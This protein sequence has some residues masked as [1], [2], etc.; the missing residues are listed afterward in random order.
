VPV[1]GGG[2]FR[3]NYNYR[4]LARHLPDLGEG[5]YRGQL[6]VLNSRLQEENKNVPVTLK[7]TAGPILTAP[8]SLLFRLGEGSATYSAG[9]SLGN[10]GAGTLAVSEVRVSTES[11]GEWLA[12]EI[13]DEGRGVQLKVQPAGLA[14]GIHNG[15]VELI[16]NAANSPHAVPVLFEVL[17]AGPPAADYATVTNLA[18]T[19]PDPVVSPGMLVK[20]RGTQITAMEETTAAEAPYPSTLAGVQVF[21]NGLEGAILRAASDELHFQ[22]P[23]DVPAGAAL[24]QLVRDGEP[25]NFVEVTVVDRLPRIEPAPVDG[26]AKTLLDDG[27]LAL[28]AALG[29]RPAQAGDVV[30][31]HLIGLGRTEP[32][33]ATGSAPADLTASVPNPL[34]VTIGTNLFTE[35]VVVDASAAL[36][37]GSPGRYAVRFTLPAGTMTG[38]RV[39]LTVNAGGALSNRVYLAIQ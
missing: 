18:S 23:Y 24:I 3:F 1:E 28:P 17:A 32:P 15:A 33:V 6:S 27:A 5:E 8:A 25:G 10:R 36:I 38:D 39:P 29:G 26:Y 30:T 11:G 22:I 37:P 9:L 14:Q 7:V 16:S 2:S 34:S 20:L 35:G 4:I 19:D 12:A 21:V 31:L 13:I